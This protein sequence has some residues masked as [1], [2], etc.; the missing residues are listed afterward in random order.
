M[1]IITAALWWAHLFSHHFASVQWAGWVPP[2]C[3]W[4]CLSVF[5]ALPLRRSSQRPAARRAAFVVTLCLAALALFVGTSMSWNLHRLVMPEPTPN[6]STLRLGYLNLSARKPAE[7]PSEPGPLDVL[8]IA[9]RAGHVDLDPAWQWVAGTEENR[10]AVNAGRCMVMSRL[11]IRRSITTYLD[12]SDVWPEGDDPD[13][14]WLSVVQ[15]ARP[16]GGQ[17]TLWVVDLPSP[18]SISRTLVIG[19]LLE[20][21]RSWRGTAFTFDEA[22]RRIAQSG[23][24]LPT[25]DLIV[26]DFNTPRWSPALDPIEDVFD[27]REVSSRVAIGPAA[28]FPSP[29]SL[30]PIDLFY[31][32][33]RWQAVSHDTH[34]IEGLRHRLITATVQREAP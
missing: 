9:N 22:G 4:L 25:P 11:P 8:V 3:L 33:G 19:R 30:W 34:I 13:S 6:A 12:F 16:G 17:L 7:W 21:A 23:A 1:L 32:T 5:L 31:T 2:V 20:H 18:I 26:G 15:F 14:A 28:T 27:A 10:D 29:W 24:T